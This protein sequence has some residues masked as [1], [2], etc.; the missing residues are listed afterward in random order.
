M[1]KR[2][3]ILF[4]SP[5]LHYPNLSGP[6]IHIENSL[7]AISE[8]ADIYLYSRVSPDEIGGLEAIDHYKKYTQEIFY[9]PLSRIYPTNIVNTLTE[10]IFKKKY[11]APHS[12]SQR[13]YQ[14]ILK[15]AQIA[16]ADLIW[17]GFGN[18]SYPLLKFIK[19][20]S[21]FKVVLQT[22]S[23]W[24]RYILRSLPY[25]K[26]GQKKEKIKIEGLAKIKEEKSATK[27]ADVT[28]V[29]SEVD[30]D[31]Y[32]HLAKDRQKIKIFSNVI[33]LDIFKPLDSKKL[34]NPAIVIGGTFWRGSPMEDAARWFIS[35]SWPIIKREIPKIYL[36]I[37]GRGSN[38]VLK[39][40]N[41]PNI[42]IE[43]QVQ[44]F[45]SYFKGAEISL[46]PLRFESGTRIKI[47]EAGALARPVISTSLGAEGLKVKNGHHLL[48]ADEPKMFARVVIKLLKN[49]RIAQRLGTNLKL[50][51]D[52]N[53]CLKSSIKEAKVIINSLELYDHK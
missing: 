43:G 12:E 34:K 48:I 30:A 32:R 23:V 37:I 1:K 36:Y 41:D 14:D 8:I 5:I 44:S 33:D 42:F 2:L 46:V 22:D 27:M 10:V 4:V 45:G 38:Q 11:F 35:E 21:S 15:K 6:H 25:I 16:E 18:I 40:I 17:L 49:K 50:L 24:S 51:V 52:K 20:N 7:K 39:D 26:D 19:K 3:K 53:Y 13:I 9:P 31:Y 47:L 28:T 29:V